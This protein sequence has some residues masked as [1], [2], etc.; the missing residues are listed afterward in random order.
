MY[1][2][3]N[4]KYLRLKNGFSQDYIADKLGYKSFTTIQKWEMGTSEPSISILKKL[5]EIYNVD[6]DTMYTID[7]ENDKTIPSKE[8]KRYPLIGTIAAGSP[9]LDLFGKSFQKQKIPRR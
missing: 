8:Y 3:K 1:L 6:M 9:I 2:A 7:L 4:L 5:S